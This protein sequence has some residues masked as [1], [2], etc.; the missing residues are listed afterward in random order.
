[1][2]TLAL[3][4]REEGHNAEAERLFRET[5][6]IQRRVLGS[7]HPDTLVD[8][9]PRNENFVLVGFIKRRS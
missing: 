3:T 6:D 5:L 7:D 9:A 1:M 4:L 2:H 8:Y